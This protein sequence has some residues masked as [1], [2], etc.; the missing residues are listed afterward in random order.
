[1]T[2]SHPLCPHCNGSHFGTNPDLVPQ[3]CMCLLLGTSTVASTRQF[4]FG[5]LRLGRFKPRMSVTTSPFTAISKQSGRLGAHRQWEKMPEKTGKIHL[6][7]IRPMFTP[8]ISTW[9]Q[10]GQS[11]PLGWQGMRNRFGGWNGVVSKVCTGRFF[12]CRHSFNSLLLLYKGYLVWM[13][14]HLNQDVNGSESQVAQT[15][16]ST[17]L[18][19]RLTSLWVPAA[20]WRFS[21]TGTKDNG[22]IRMEQSLHQA[23]F[24]RWSVQVLVPFTVTNSGGKPLLFCRFPHHPWIDVNSKEKIP[25]RATR[26]EFQNGSEFAFVK[27][28]IFWIDLGCVED[29]K[30]SVGANRGLAMA[31]MPG[32]TNNLL[33]IYTLH[34]DAIRCPRM[35]LPCPASLSPRTAEATLPMAC[36]TIWGSGRN[37]RSIWPQA[38]RHKSMA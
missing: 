8:L 6:K 30:F 10:V 36:S 13:P 15:A 17:C 22:I 29:Y 23:V 1:M 21:A 5:E 16:T 4:S 18:L 26:P 19:T 7:I 9:H 37:M 14:Y 28:H 2:C 35:Q 32:P 27:D 38:T 11:G 31:E 12:K 25:T 20:S 24:S 34:E 3:K 33:V